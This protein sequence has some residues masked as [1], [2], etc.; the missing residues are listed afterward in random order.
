MVERLSPARVVIRRS[1][2]RQALAQQGLGFAVLPHR[3]QRVTE[4]VEAE[5]QPAWITDSPPQ[6]ETFTEEEPRLVILAQRMRHYAQKGVRGRHVPA[7]VERSTNH[8]AFLNQAP[9]LGITFPDLIG[10]VPE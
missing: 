8:E 9:R 1:A 7:V 4:K 2:Q 3:I 6:R 10:N 5:C